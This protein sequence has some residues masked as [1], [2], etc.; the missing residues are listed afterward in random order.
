[1]PSCKSG[2]RSKG[3]ARGQLTKEYL[4]IGLTDQEGVSEDKCLRRHV[5]AWPLEW[6]CVG[7]VTT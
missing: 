3:C 1:M 5:L 2:R 6:A 7:M 4:H